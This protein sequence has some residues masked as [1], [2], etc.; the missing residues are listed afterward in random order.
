MK[1]VDN[2][3]VQKKVGV[4]Q[5]FRGANEIPPHGHGV[6]PAGGT[7]NLAKDKN[8]LGVEPDRRK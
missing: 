1:K 7:S 6:K 4:N 2:I 3:T 5:L 8:V